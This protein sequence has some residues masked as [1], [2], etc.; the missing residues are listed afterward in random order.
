MPD[1]VKKTYRLYALPLTAKNI[2]T[3]AERRFA[4]V[5]TRYVLIYSAEEVDGGAEIG[6]SEIS[7][8]TVGD[9][10]WLTDCNLILLAEDAK[11]REAEIAGSLEKR[12]DA[13]EQALK[14]EKE[15]QKEG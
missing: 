15:K 5:T 8:L 14:A 2:A 13:F 9:A 11:G 6:E 7:R 3:A 4:R 10:D 1:I 12:L